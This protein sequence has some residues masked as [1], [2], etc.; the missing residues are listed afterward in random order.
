MG[1][2][3]RRF[4]QRITRFLGKSTEEQRSELPENQDAWISEWKRKWQNLP[5]TQKDAIRDAVLDRDK[6]PPWLQPTGSDLERLCIEEYAF[7]Q[8]VCEFV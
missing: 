8:T 4:Y 3:R 5:R 2:L 7:R 6:N 1:T